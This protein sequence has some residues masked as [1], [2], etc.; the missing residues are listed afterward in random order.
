M[1]CVFNRYYKSNLTRIILLQ[2]RTFTYKHQR[3]NY[4]FIYLYFYFDMQ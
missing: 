4:P 3:D 1:K 2:Y